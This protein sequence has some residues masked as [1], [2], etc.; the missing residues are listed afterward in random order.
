MTAPH[1]KAR[2]IAD[3]F[4]PP[5]PNVT[6]DPN[7]LLRAEIAAALEAER[8]A[9][10][11]EQRNKDHMP[12]GPCCIALQRREQEGYRRGLDEAAKIVEVFRFDRNMLST[13][14]IVKLIAQQIRQRG[15]N[16]LSSYED[17]DSDD[18][19]GQK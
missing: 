9:G 6:E 8:K 7:S 1:A 10:A 3:W 12:D 4:L 2:D 11:E 18:A 14:N 13:T 17:A 16:S 19:G 15:Q 5:N